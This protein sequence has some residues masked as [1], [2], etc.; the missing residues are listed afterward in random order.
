MSSYSKCMDFP[1]N[2]PRYGEMQQNPLHGGS[3]GNWY[4][5]FSHSLGVFFPLDSHP[6][7]YFIRWEMHGFPHQF[8]KLRKC[9][10]TNRMAKVWEIEDHNF[11]IVWVLFSHLIPILWHTSSFGKSMDF[12]INFPHYGKMQQ[13]PPYGENLGNWYSYFSHSMGAYFPFSILWYTSSHRECMYFLINFLYYGKKQ[14]N[15]S[16]GESLGNW[17]LYFSHSMGAFFH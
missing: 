6:M 3:L 13:N 9:N 12:P 14:P 17:Y 10:K 11:L 16:N 2:F 7:A 5:Y 1:I 15:P 8:P 4:S